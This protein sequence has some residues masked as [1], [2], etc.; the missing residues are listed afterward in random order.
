M[1]RNTIAQSEF[2]GSPPNK[3]YA[4]QSVD[5]QVQLID[6]VNE[7]AAALDNMTN[8]GTPAPGTFSTLNAT[9]AATFDGAVTLG[10]ADAD[11]T[12]IL[13]AL[14]HDG[15]TVGFYGTAPIAKQTGVAV[16]AGG[17]H[18]ALVALGLIGA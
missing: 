13:G 18:A 6:M 2:P 5:N 3:E 16:T 15:T 10:N 7:H 17:I 4:L 8:A 1:A 9:G 11:P 14:N 12:N